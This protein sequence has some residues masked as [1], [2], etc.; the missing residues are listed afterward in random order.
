MFKKYLQFFC[1]FGGGW[2]VG[3]G[4]GLGGGEVCYK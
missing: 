1:F 2:G 3:V 4:W